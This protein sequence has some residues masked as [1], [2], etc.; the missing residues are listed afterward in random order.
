[1]FLIRHRQCHDVFCCVAV[2]HISPVHPTDKT[3]GPIRISI[4]SV[5]ID[6]V[7]EREF[8]TC[9]GTGTSQRFAIGGACL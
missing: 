2:H 8:L 5:K 6:A 4:F 7:V 3:L 1:L 9:S